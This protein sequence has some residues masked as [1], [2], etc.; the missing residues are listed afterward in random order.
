MARVLEGKNILDLDSTTAL[1]ALAC[2][3]SM[4]HPEFNPMN[5]NFGIFTPL[6]DATKKKDRKSA[7]ANRALQKI[8]EYLQ[9]E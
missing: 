5:V 3:I 9:D 8:K 2:Y 4:P 7:Y 1:G 6:S